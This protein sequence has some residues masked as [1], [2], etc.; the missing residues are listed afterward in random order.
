M[1]A[2][3]QL[4]LVLDL[5]KNAEDEAG[6][7]LSEAQTQLEQA[8]TQLKELQEYYRGYEETFNSRRCGITASSFIRDRA[9]LN[10]LSQAQKQQTYAVERA[11][12][13][14]EYQR[15]VWLEAHQKSQ[16]LQELVDRRREQAN[17]AL[18]RKEQKLLDEWVQQF[19][20]RSRNY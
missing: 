4:E 6:K 1:A 2:A 20:S 17:K 5:A 3:T 7:Q 19:T 11:S 16:S 9:F 13:C 14:V 18:N 8:E 10:Q 15:Q 12:Q